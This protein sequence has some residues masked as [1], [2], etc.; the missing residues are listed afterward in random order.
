MK[1][2]FSETIGFC[3]CEI[4][5]RVVGMAH[6]PDLDRIS[7]LKDKAKAERRALNIGQKLITRREDFLVIEDLTTLIEIL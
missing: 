3:G 1:S 4:I 2:L 7:N 5:R 6:V